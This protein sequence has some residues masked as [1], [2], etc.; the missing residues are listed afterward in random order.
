LDS[1]AKWKNHCR[2]QANL[3]RDITILVINHPQ[4]TI[5]TCNTKT[6]IK[7]KLTYLI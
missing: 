7:M 5:N 4:R 3:S 2:R 6:M 1:Q